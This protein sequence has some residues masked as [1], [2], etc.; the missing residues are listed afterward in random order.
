MATEFCSEKISRNRLG[1]V[2]II[3]RKKVLIP[4]HSKV[5]GRANS[6]ARNGR[7]WQEKNKFYKKSCSSKQNWQ[8][9]LVRD[10]L[11]NGIPRVCFYCCSKEE[12]NS[13]FFSLPQNGSE[14]NSKCLLLFLFMYRI[15][16]IFLL[17]RNGS[18]R[19]SECFL[20]R[21]TAG[22]RQNSRIPAEQSNCFVY[23]VFHGIIFL[24]KIPNPSI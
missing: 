17:C 4:R 12:W 16:S 3:P 19:N 15:P 23:S 9:V 8:H 1:M 13:E 10:M 14:Q 18:K 6:E 2:S 20:L 7:K 5:Y 24:L 11:R 21:G 22:F